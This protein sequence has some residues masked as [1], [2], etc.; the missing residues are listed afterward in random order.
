MTRG[1]LDETEAT[2][3][4]VTFERGRIVERGIFHD[5]IYR[6]IDISTN[7]QPRRRF[8]SHHMVTFAKEYLGWY[9]ELCAQLAIPGSSGQPQPA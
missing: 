4:I 6:E 3:T 7:D 8:A 5:C 2:L 1:L 9:E